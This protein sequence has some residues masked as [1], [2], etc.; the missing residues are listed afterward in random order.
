MRC[1]DIEEDEFVG[2]FPVISDGTIR[3]V[4]CIAK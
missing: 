2:L 3:G 4:T 1:G